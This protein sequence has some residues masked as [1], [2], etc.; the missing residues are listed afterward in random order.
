MNTEN[1]RQELAK[2]I[3]S[4]ENKEILSYIRAIFESHPDSWFNDLPEAV[5]A[6]VN[7]GLDQSKKKE[8]RPH[9]EVMKKYKA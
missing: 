5:K 3:L 8:I 6:S 1:T 4:T 2:K 9:A 7:R